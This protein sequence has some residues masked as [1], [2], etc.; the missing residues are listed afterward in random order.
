MELLNS[1]DEEIKY[2]IDEFPSLA[3]DLAEELRQNEYQTDAVKYYER[4]RELPGGPDPTTLLQL[5]RCYLAT[6]QESFAEE[7]FLGAIEVDPDIIDARFEL[8]Y[9]YEKAKENEEALILA[10]EAMALRD[11]RSYAGMRSESYSYHDTAADARE[12]AGMPQ[13]TSANQSARIRSQRPPDE[14]PGLQPIMASGMDQQMADGQVPDHTSDYHTRSMPAP[15]K[16][17]NI[18]AR[19]PILSAGATGVP[20]QTITYETS[21]PV[22]P[23]LGTG[24]QNR[25]QTFVAEK[26]SSVAVPRSQDARLQR[27]SHSEAR[28]SIPKR[29]RPKRLAGPAKRLRDEKDRALRLSHQYESVKHLKKQIEAGHSD[30]MATWMDA[31][32]ELVDEF[33]SLKRFYS[34]DKYLNFLGSSSAN[35]A[36]QQPETELSQLYQ[37]LARCTYPRLPN[38]VKVQANCFKATQTE[39]MNRERTSFPIDNDH[40]ISFDDWLDVFIDYAI[41]LALEHR[42][43]ESYQIC[44]AAK[45]STVFQSEEHEFFIYI[46]WSGKQFTVCMHKSIANG[47]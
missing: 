32:K 36:V 35:R 6:G 28:P 20:S 30:L 9:M 43:Q 42:Q 4:L 25:Y 37:R 27:A 12:Y 23:A 33:R 29:Y 40:G 8:A 13:D 15:P 34:W 39:Q 38:D 1:T 46:A 10:A 31:S 17:Y 3:F 7:C 11:A 19:Q 44:E 16:Q 41:G 22:D 21:I 26:P 18:S 5:G 2:F 47:Y 14:W 24:L 45:D